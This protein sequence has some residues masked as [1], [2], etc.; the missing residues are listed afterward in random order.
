VSLLEE[1]ETAEQLALDSAAL[2]L[3]EL[4]LVEVAQSGEG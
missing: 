1:S 3:T 4:M 2:L